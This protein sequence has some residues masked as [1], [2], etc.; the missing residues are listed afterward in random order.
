MRVGTN[1]EGGCILP[2]ERGT[3]SPTRPN[4]YD[5]H[6][7]PATPR[8][9]SSISTGALQQF[10][11][12]PLVL[13]IPIDRFRDSI[14]SIAARVPLQLV[15]GEAGINCITPIMPEPISDEGDQAVW[16][17]QLIQNGFNHF[18]MR[19]FAITAEVIDRTSF[20]FE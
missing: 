1:V 8:C 5:P 9:P 3:H 2:R 12:P 6:L 20:S 4:I 11:P 17:A 15:F 16:F 13:K 19:Q 18:K 7:V 14:P 10:L